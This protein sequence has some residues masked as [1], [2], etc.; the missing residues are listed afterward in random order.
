MNSIKLSV[1][2][3]IIGLIVALPQVYGLLKP[4]AFAAAL[5]KF[6]RSLPWGYA[7]MLL[8]TGWFLYNLKTDT[9]SDFA[10]FKPVMLGGFALLGVGC[11]FFVKDFLA[12]RGLAV[13]LL[14]VAKLVLD[15]ARLLE[16]PWRL[17]AVVLMYIW[18]VASLWFTIA[19][20]R[21]R[22]F[23]QWITATDSRIR[24]GS[25]IRL[26]IGLLLVIL[27][28]TVYRTSGLL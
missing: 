24:I 5:R 14:L 21:L 6:P 23:I 16:T 7:L 11:C 26:A 18:I 17:V 12:V 10:N 9:T 2:S 3:T 13:V 20:W 8:G 15:S 28:L 4:A 19:P 25:G 27:G 1:L 22:D